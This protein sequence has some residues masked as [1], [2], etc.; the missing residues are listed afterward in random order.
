MPTY[1]A[2]AH[3]PCF[4]AIQQH[5]EQ[6]WARVGYGRPV[7]KDGACYHWRH[8]EQTQSGFQAPQEWLRRS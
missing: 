7:A 3:A 4:V 6:I 5:S 8:G 1:D 2:S